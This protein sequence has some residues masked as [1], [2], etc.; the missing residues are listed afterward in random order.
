[1]A[2]MSVQQCPKL[3]RALSRERSPFLLQFRND[4]LKTRVDIAK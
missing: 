2:C 1:M 4:K 3:S